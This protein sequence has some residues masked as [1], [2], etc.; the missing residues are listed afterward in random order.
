MAL[1]LSS[2]QS[3]QLTKQ[4]KGYISVSTTAWTATTVDDICAGSS[5]EDKDYVY[6]SPVTLQLYCSASAP[7]WDDDAQGWYIAASPT[8]R[9]IFIFFKVGAGNYTNKTIPLSRDTGITYTGLSL[10]LGANA[11]RK[12]DFASDASILWDESE[13]TFCFNTTQSSSTQII[14]AGA[15][16]TPTKGWYY[17]A[18]VTVT[19]YLEYNFSGTWRIMTFGGGMI[20]CDGTNIRVFNAG[21]IA[22]TIYYIKY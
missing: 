3:T 9:C 5:F 22:I 20:F 19:T 1:T 17:I 7:A 13:N 4:R 12:I 8:H 14:N 2:L 10:T 6:F 11:D 15:S 16:W 21:G 18:N